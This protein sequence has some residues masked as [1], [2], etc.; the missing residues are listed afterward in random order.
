LFP[1]FFIIKN[2]QCRKLRQFYVSD[3]VVMSCGFFH[4]TTVSDSAFPGDFHTTMSEIRLIF[5][6][7]AIY[8]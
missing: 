1:L 6:N 3:C 7:N 5:L 2:D 4:R 8:H